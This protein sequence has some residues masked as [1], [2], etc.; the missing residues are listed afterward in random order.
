MAAAKAK[1]AGARKFI[2]MRNA[3]R[4]TRNNT[5]NPKPEG[6][7]PKE[8]RNPNSRRSAGDWLRISDFGFPSAFGFRISDFSS[9]PYFSLAQLLQQQFLERCIRA[10]GEKVD[11][12][13]LAILPQTRQKTLHRLLIGFHAV[14]AKGNFLKRARFGIDQFQ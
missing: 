13:S 9:S 10:G 4:G 5:Q 1:A 8:I 2:R 12:A 14:A 3:E 6:R 7:N 11:A